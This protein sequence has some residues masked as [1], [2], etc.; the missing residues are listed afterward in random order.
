MAHAVKTLDTAL[1]ASANNPN[2]RG[3]SVFF[4]NRRLRI[5]AKSPVG[6]IEITKM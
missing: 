6:L 1:S 2:I 3:M 5:L 4:M